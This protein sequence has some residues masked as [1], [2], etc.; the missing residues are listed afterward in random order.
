MQTQAEQAAQINQVFFGIYGLLALAMTIRLFPPA[1]KTVRHAWRVYYEWPQKNRMED[2]TNLNIA[3]TLRVQEA[4]DQ[5]VA[6]DFRPFGVG[7]L[8]AV[9][10]TAPFDGWLYQDSSGEIM[11]EV[12]DLPNVPVLV[13]LSTW[14]SD[15]TYLETNYPL[16]GNINQ[17]D[18]VSHR[19]TTSIT[20]AY[21]HQRKLVAHHQ[22]S[23][24]TPV[25]IHD[26]TDHLRWCGIFRSKYLRR[27]N[28]PLILDGLFIHGGTFLIALVA[29]LYC[30]FFFLNPTRLDRNA[31]IVALVIGVIAFAYFR[32]VNRVVARRK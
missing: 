13:G 30:A 19:V 7:R 4:V 28:L 21:D 14:F 3:P 1:W 26:M 23:H 8:H 22:Q 12:I 15:E 24:G 18:F 27:Q 17:P 2:V 16:G 25:V 5:L 6:L 10:S 31:A 32:I 11:V 29:V 20:D 9:G